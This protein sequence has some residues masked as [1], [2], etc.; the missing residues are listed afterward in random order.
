MIFSNCLDPFANCSTPSVSSVSPYQAYRPVHGSL[1]P[2]KDSLG[3]DIFRNNNGDY[4]VHSDLGCYLQTELDNIKIQRLHP[5][6]QG[7]DHYL[8]CVE[9]PNAYII[10][11]SSYRVVKDLSMD[12]EAKDWGIVCSVEDLGTDEGG[13]DSCL[14]PEC[15]E[16]LYYFG[17]QE[18][19]TLI[20]DNY[21]RKSIYTWQE[22]WTEARGEEESVQ[23]NMENKQ[24]LYIWQYHLGIGQETV[25]VCRNIQFTKENNPPD[26]I[27]LSLVA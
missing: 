4:I 1:V 24:N 21:G 8:G 12:E 7:G 19:L 13:F 10:K 26:R 20:K 2:R 3:T 16:G 9:D 23:V 27:P 14:A 5:L 17:I 22:D 15:C 6:C 25:L 11:G 18:F